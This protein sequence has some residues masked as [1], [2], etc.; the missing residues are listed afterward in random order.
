MQLTKGIPA[1]HLPFP[2]LRGSINSIK[3]PAYL[4]IKYDGEA[5]Y[6]IYDKDKG[7]YLINKYGTTRSK[8]HKLD[9][10]VDIISPTNNNCIMLGELVA[11]DGKN[12][13]LYNLL[14]MKDDDS[15]KFVI[16]D[17]KPDGMAADMSLEVRKAY[18]TTLMLVGGLQDVCASKRVNNAK[19]AQDAF[20]EVVKYGYEGVVVK[21][22]K[23]RFP[24]GTCDWAKIKFKDQTVYTVLNVDPVKERM[25]ISVPNTT[26]I[27]VCGVKL[28][29]KHKNNIKA[30]DRVLIEHQGIL[31][32]GSLRHPVF[33]RKEEN[34]GSV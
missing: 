17:V 10:I 7:P 1:V 2:E 5:N 11:T 29:S 30:G 20:N 16:Y 12:G 25:E 3:Y 24:N 14:K 6:F 27:V 13:D 33:I 34:D 18:L 22:M 9:K 19:E 26:G 21:S 8:W 32:S 23:G 4:D 15:I 28:C 31:S